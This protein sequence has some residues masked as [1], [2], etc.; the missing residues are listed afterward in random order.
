MVEATI[1]NNQIQ[2][3]S[4]NANCGWRPSLG[5]ACD[6][7]LE[8]VGSCI[9]DFMITDLVEVP[10]IIGSAC[11]GGDAILAPSSYCSMQSTNGGVDGEDCRGFS[12]AVRPNGLDTISSA[13]AMWDCSW[14]FKNPLSL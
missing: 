6:R 4:R 5:M 9:L 3:R 8:A 14:L 10:L 12:K 2:W 13:S 11:E 1:S 7:L